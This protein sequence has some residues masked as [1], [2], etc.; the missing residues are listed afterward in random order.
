MAYKQAKESFEIV[1]REV[2]SISGINK[3]QALKKCDNIEN[4]IVR[5]HNSLETCV[6]DSN[7]EIERLKYQLEQLN[8]D[9]VRLTA[10]EKSLEAKE[11]SLKADKK[12]AE[13]KEESL[14][15]QMRSLSRKIDEA[16]EKI[17]EEGKKREEAVLSAATSFIPVF[18][19]FNA[20]KDNDPKKLIPGYSLVNG[21]ISFLS[22]EKER[23][24]DEC[25]RLEREVEETESYLRGVLNELMTINLK[26]ENISCELSVI[27]NSIVRIGE[28]IKKR[29]RDLTESGNAL[30][31]LKISQSK[32]ALVKNDL[33]MIRECVDNDVFEKDI[34]NDFIRQFRDTQQH[35]LVVCC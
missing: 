25:N 23:L 34:F 19:I 30:K 32:F 1:L 27:R 13:S 14:K 24:E 9:E 21:L 7:E 15:S 33:F 31:E 18:G 4:E 22:Q 17:K 11:K 29:G 28:K 3:A 2:N 8:A 35:F 20:I 26:R 12:K 6:E 5:L 16:R 10:Q